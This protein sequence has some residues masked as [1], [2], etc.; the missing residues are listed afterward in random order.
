MYVL[1]TGDGSIIE[2]TLPLMH[3]QRHLTGLF[4]PREHANTIARAEGADF[5]VLKH[6]Y[7]LVITC[8]PLSPHS[9]HEG[10]A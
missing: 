1:S 4:T 8:V 3:Q 5:W 2:L 10:L 9:N 7:G 6:N